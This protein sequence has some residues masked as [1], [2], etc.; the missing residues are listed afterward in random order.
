MSRYDDPPPPYHKV[1]DSDSGEHNWADPVKSGTMTDPYDMPPPSAPPSDINPINRSNPCTHF[2]KSLMQRLK[3]YQ[4]IEHYP[5]PAV[6]IMCVVSLL[7]T[8]MI[9]FLFKMVVR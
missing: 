4:Y 1:C 5:H 8:L 7:I 3:T 2:F 6:V 9:F